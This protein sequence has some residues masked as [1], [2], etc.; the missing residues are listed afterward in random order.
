MTGW[1]MAGVWAAV[2]AIGAGTWWLLIAW[3]GWGALGV[4][5]A[6]V[7]LAVWV[8]TMVDRMAPPRRSIHR[9][10]GAAVAP[11]PGSRIDS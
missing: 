1:R 5:I 6:A 3:F 7:L 2:A 4:A 11:P 8:G 9:S 10:G